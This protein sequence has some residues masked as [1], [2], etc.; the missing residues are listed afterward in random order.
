MRLED[1][2]QFVTAHIDHY[3]GVHPHSDGELTAMEAKLGG[4][5]PAQLAWLL[6]THGYTQATGVDNLVEA[7]RATLLCRESINLPRHLVVLNDWGDAGV[8]LLDL[9]SGR[10]CWCGTY[11]V[12]RIASGQEPVGDVDWFEDFAEWTRSRLDEALE[13]TGS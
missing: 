2:K 12:E 3:S 11:D 6:R 8:V 9:V 4:K 7:V 1:F 5:F 13:E 10:C